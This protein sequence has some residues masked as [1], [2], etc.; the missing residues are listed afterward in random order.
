[1]RH[2]FNREDRWAPIG[3]QKWIRVHSSMG[4]MHHPVYTKRFKARQST[5]K[6]EIFLAACIRANIEPTPRQARRWNMKQGL[7]YRHHHEN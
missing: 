2:K 6:N 7:A 1:M 4:E 5:I 3:D